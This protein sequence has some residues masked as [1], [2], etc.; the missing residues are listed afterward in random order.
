MDT[1]KVTIARRGDAAQPVDIPWAGR[2]PETWSAR[3]LVALWRQ[4]ADLVNPY[5]VRVE[6]VPEGSLFIIEA[7]GGAVTAGPFRVDAG[8]LAKALRE[9]TAADVMF[10]TR[11]MAEVLT[12]RVG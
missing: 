6:T 10:H 2:R 9:P 8:A 5:T 3:D 4:F 11:R 12:Q 1:M 7:P